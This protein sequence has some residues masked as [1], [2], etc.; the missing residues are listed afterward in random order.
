[1]NVDTLLAAMP[2]LARQTAQ[3][4][5]PHNDAAMREFEITNANRAW[6]W[7]AQVGHE[8]LSLRYLE[9]IADGSAYEGR[10][11][12]GN[13]Q[14][15]DGKRYKGR[16]P[17]QITGR[18]NYTAAAGALKLDLVNRPQIAAEPQH[19][20]RVSAWW[21]FANGL[22]GISD[23]GDVTAATRR[24]NGGLNGLSDRQ[25]RHARCKNLG[26]TAVL[27]GAGAAPE[28]AAEEMTASAVADNG[29]LHVF[30]AT[31]GAL[32]YAY[33]PAGK[34]SWSGGE[35]GKRIAGMSAFAPAPAGRQIRGVAAA[36]A[37]NGNLHVFAVLDDGSVVFTWQAKGSSGWSG[38]AP[39]KGIAGLS[40][41]APAP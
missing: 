16:G 40:P 29:N 7:L 34:T 9:E 13:T 10:K 22:N 33:Q 1:M 25:S 4:Y 26:P 20:F 2:G 8:S 21:W 11:D 3:A 38:G 27:P 17:I 36:K 18:Y 14:P 15:G 37:A 6:M 19:A 30:S 23:T 41:F 5:L 24:I 31:P 39:G 32:F 12:L 35:A 28:P